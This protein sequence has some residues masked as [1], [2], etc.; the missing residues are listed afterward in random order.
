[1]Q[2]IVNEFALPI[3]VPNLSASTYFDQLEDLLS[4]ILS[5]TKQ[6]SLSPAQ[7]KQIQQ[8]P[9]HPQHEKAHTA[10]ITNI[11]NKCNA[12]GAP[13]RIPDSVITSKLSYGSVDTNSP[14]YHHPHRAGSN[15]SRKEQIIFESE[16]YVGLPNIGNTCYINSFLIILYFCRDFR[17]FL[18]KEQPTDKSLNCLARIFTDLD[19]K[20]TV[21]L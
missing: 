8:Y 16:D 21:G 5:S 10:I 13:S 3:L 17:K 20:N 9:K 1:M 2:S 12:F 18:V 7:L 15:E 19:V 6:L 4:I 11:I 14:D